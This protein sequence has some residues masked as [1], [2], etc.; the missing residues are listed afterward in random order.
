ML[1]LLSISFQAYAEKIPCTRLR[2]LNKLQSKVNIIDYEPQII[3][4]LASRTEL[5][6]KTGDK[7]VLGLTVAPLIHNLSLKTTIIEQGN[8]LCVFLEEVEFHFGYQHQY[9]YIDSRYPKGSCEYNTILEHE[10][11]HVDFNNQA[12][13]RYRRPFTNTVRQSFRN[14]DPLEL[15]NDKYATRNIELWKQKL[16]DIPYLDH[17]KDEM[18]DFQDLKHGHIDSDHNYKR[19]NRKCKNW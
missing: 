13:A 18:K 12:L 8:T 1:F 11:L 9:V 5:I 2:Y 16:Q 4:Q 15:K 14:V 7:N 19:T 10:N 17:L 6:K 3:Y